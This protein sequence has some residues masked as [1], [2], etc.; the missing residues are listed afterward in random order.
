M[1]HSILESI[2]GKRKINEL[3]SSIWGI[4]EKIPNE[5]IYVRARLRD[6][7]GNAKSF[8]R[9]YS[10]NDLTALILRDAENCF[11]RIPAGEREKHYVHTITFN[12]KTS[13]EEHSLKIY[14]K[15]HSRYSL[16]WT[17]PRSRVS[18]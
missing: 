13:E 5:S 10:P 14:L 11:Y 2:T 15:Q 18:F 3:G 17:I 1:V 8:C 4:L 12:A 16:K 9:K 7:E 6:S